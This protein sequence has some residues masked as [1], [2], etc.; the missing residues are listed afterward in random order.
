MPTF[1]FILFVEFV[2]WRVETSYS[3]KNRKLN[4]RADIIETLILGSSHALQGINPKILGEYSYNLANVSQDYYYDLKILEKYIK[5]LNNLKSAIVTVDYFS[6]KYKMSDGPESYR[7]YF[8]SQDMQIYPEALLD[9][10]DIKNFSRIMLYGPHKLIGYLVNG[11]PVPDIDENGFQCVQDGTM[12]EN[13]RDR[14]RYHHEKLMNEEYVME[15]I[16]KLNNIVDLLAKHNVRVIFV[17]LPV[18]SSY[19]AYIDINNYEQTNVYIKEISKK[20]DT[21]YFNYFYNETYES[22]DFYDGDHLNCRGAGKLSRQLA[23]D[24]EN[25]L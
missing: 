3:V 20:F 1:F 16:N 4:E 9:K 14:V 12:K 18:H 10:I 19:R 2:L 8:Y 5:S 25:N 15:N 7:Q 23:I 6:L 11:V 17:M 13:G 24:I 22:N 21:K